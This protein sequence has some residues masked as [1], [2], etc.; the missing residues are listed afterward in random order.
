MKAPFTRQQQESLGVIKKILQG[1]WQLE[2]AQAE[3]RL[4][5]DIAALRSVLVNKGIVTAEEL[6]AAKAEFEAGLS[7]E[8]ALNP[9]LQQAW[10]EVNR[11][12]GEIQKQQ[13]QKP[14]KKR[15]RRQ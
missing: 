13:Q 6:D 1:M 9:E 8:E 4:F 3:R 2:V 5:S 11:V 14:K 15:R 7:V 12:F 10:D